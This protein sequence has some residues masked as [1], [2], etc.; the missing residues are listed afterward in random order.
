[1]GKK[2]SVQ[3]HNNWCFCMARALNLR[4]MMQFADLF[5]DF[6]IVSPL[7]IQLSWSPNIRQ[8][9]HQR[10]CLKRNCTTH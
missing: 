8:N 1:M 3:W 5:P 9:C 7:A 10:R 2:L 4:R 6:E